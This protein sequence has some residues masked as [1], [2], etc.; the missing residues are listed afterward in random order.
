MFLPCFYWALLS[1]NYT[2]GSLA[3]TQASL[4]KALALMWLWTILLVLEGFCPPA[5]ISPQQSQ[6]LPCLR[7]ASAAAAIHTHQLSSRDE[8]NPLPW[9][10]SRCKRGTPCWFPFHLPKQ[11]SLTSVCVSKRIKNTTEIP[12]F[13]FFVFF[14]HVSVQSAA[15]PRAGL[16]AIS[17][18]LYFMWRG[19][20][21][22]GRK[23]KLSQK[24]YD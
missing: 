23:L 15:P 18:Y 6:T 8:S 24:K 14:G 2:H 12:F 13:V 4:Q 5:C 21:W 9:S 22:K 20:R 3:T 10:W 17:S 1:R 7:K 11:E 19:Y 16:C